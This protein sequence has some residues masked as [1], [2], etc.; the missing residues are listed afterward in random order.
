[1]FRA[2]RMVPDALALLLWSVTVQMCYGNLPFAATQRAF[3]VAPPMEAAPVVFQYLEGHPRSNAAKPLPELTR[4]ALRP[5]L[6]MF[7]SPALL[8]S[9]GRARSDTVLLTTVICVPS[10]DAAVQPCAI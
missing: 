4:T 8:Q 5:Q 2:V 7:M 3:V 6:P 10:F 9:D 1:V